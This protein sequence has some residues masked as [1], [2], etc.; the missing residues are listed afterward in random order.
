MLAI[1]FLSKLK[2]DFHSLFFLVEV[3]TRTPWLFTVFEYFTHVITRFYQAK[4]SVGKFTNKQKHFPWKSVHY[5]K[6]KK[7]KYFTSE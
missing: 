6:E 7:N 4:P 3:K 5:I 1:Q 2:L